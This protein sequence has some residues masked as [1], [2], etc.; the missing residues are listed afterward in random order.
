MSTWSAFLK[1]QTWLK[2]VLEAKAQSQAWFRSKRLKLITQSTV[3][4]KWLI[5]LVVSN[6]TLEDKNNVKLLPTFPNEVTW[7]VLTC[8]RANDELAAI[9]APVF[10]GS[11]QNCDLE[12]EG[13]ISIKSRTG[14]EKD[15]SGSVDGIGGLWGGCT[16]KT[17]SHEYTCLSRLQRSSRLLHCLTTS[18]PCLKKK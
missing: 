1:S 8:H 16:H 2:L 6:L 15:I 13:Q 10:D 12:T 14:Q 18:S 17:V 7:N 11:R 4:Y 3:T 5:I 9:E